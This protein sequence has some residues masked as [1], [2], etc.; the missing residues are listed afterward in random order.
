MGSQID[1]YF[2]EIDALIKFQ[3]EDNVQ[4]HS[5]IKRK[6]RG[7]LGLINEIEVDDENQYGLYKYEYHKT[8]YSYLKANDDM[9]G[10]NK[11]KILA[12]RYEKYTNTRTEETQYVLHPSVDFIASND[13][14]QDCNLKTEILE[15]LKQI[16]P[17]LEDELVEINIVDK[18]TSEIQQIFKKLSGITK[19]FEGYQEAINCEFHMHK[20]ADRLINEKLIILKANNN[21]EEENKSSRIENVSM[22]LIDH[23]K[24]LKLLAHK[25]A[26]SKRK[27]FISFLSNSSNKIEILFKNVINTEEEIN[28]RA[29]ILGSCFHP[30]RTKNPK[31]PYVLHEIYKS[32]GDELF[33]LI[34]KFKEHLLNELKKTLELKDHENYGNELWK[35]TI[36]YHNA[37]KETESIKERR[38]QRALF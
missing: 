3:L 26:Y 6:F 4:N 13:I 18:L 19:T 27:E 2:S 32:Q 10:A 22:E 12:E 15:E 38:Y 28:R 30:D 9:E 8:Y 17:I 25:D 14:N 20:L 24:C 21:S 16:S 5:E 1:I 33:R 7:V 34:S 35:I 23:L 11:Q 37:S 31:C 29:R 36:D